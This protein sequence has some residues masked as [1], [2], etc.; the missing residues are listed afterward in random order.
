V[1]KAKLVEQL[2]FIRQA[3][4]KAGIWDYVF[5]GY[6][7]MLGAVRDGG[8]IGHDSDADI[9]LLA[10][11]FDKQ[12]EDRFYEALW[13]Y[14]LFDAR[15]K[16]VR[17]SDTNRILWVSVKREK[18]GMKT[19]IWFQQRWNGYYWHSKGK[20]WVWKIGKNL[21]PPL[22][23]NHT[24]VG[25]GIPESYFDTLVSINWY[26]Q[27]DWKIPMN[28]GR[29]LDFYYPNWYFPKKG[30]SSASSY[31]LDVPSWKDKSGWKIRMR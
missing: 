12:A 8:I 4:I 22:D 24:A 19:C 17:R 28:F 11:K 15:H 26:G 1:I 30:G 2:K 9:C 7:T 3:A 13:G 31:I 18:Q 16:E 25:K 23:Q 20:N 14:K 6:G 5:L 29:C 21:N 10:D 27:D